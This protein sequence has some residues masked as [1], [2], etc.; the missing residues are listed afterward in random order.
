MRGVTRSGRRRLFPAA[1]A[2]ARAC[3][4]ETTECR[5]RRPQRAFGQHAVG[6]GL[7]DGRLAVEAGLVQFPACV[8]DGERVRAVFVHEEHQRLQGLMPRSS[9]RRSS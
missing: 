4:C 7:V 5:R 9:R 2:P 1:L 3:S 8:L 6:D